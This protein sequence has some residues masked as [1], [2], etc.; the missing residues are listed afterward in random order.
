MSFFRRVLLPDSGADLLREELALAFAA[1]GLQV[2]RLPPEAFA[3][4]AARQGGESRAEKGPQGEAARLTAD[5]PA[6]LFSVNFQGL[7][8][9][10]EVLDLLRRH[11][12][13]AAV[14]CV[15]NPW[16]LLSGVR[17]P[18]WKSLPLFVTDA[19]FIPGLKAQGATRVLHLPLAA[20]PAHFLPN[21]RREA[22][23]PAPEGLAPFV[24][25][26][27]S[28][29]PG[30]EAFF[31]GRRLPPKMLEE[32]KDMLPRGL[33]PDFSWWEER[34]AG[35][36]TAPGTAPAGLALRWPGKG[37]RLAALGA[38]ESALAWRSLCLRAAAGSA[39]RGE[40]G[41][42]LDVFGDVGWQ[43][44]LPPRARLHPP[45]DY[46]ARLPG[47]Y[48]K[49]RF[50]LCLTS[51]QLPAGLTQRHFDIWMAGGLGLTDASPGLAL[52]PEELVR[53]VRFS[54][55]AEIPRS[56]RKAEGYPGGRAALIAA[57]R[58]LLLEKHT[59]GHRVRT[60]LDALQDRRGR[61]GCL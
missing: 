31:A 44:L 35:R 2:S 29:F 23:F 9:L 28:A 22:A 4:R 14:W 27:R 57:W 18:R 61:S 36:E 58:Q 39:L 60:V 54:S 59:Y 24:F 49:A 3:S 50:S 13:Q 26:G 42:G 41:P 48:A 38:E 34:L 56:A 43:G 12:G 40:D 33:R 8:A 17:D 32:A 5:G 21:P 47:I 53:P 37:A 1:Q 20:S 25:V 51:M 30:K 10:R 52:F 15:D 19:S 46:Y 45:L 16:N 7:A 55:P 6:L 11:N